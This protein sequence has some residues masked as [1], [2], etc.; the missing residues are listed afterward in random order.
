MLTISI[1][2]F[3]RLLDFI[4]GPILGHFWTHLGLF[5][6]LGHS[7]WTSKWSWK[8]CWGGFVGLLGVFW[9]V[10]RPLVEVLVSV[11]GVLGSLCGALG[12]LCGALGILGATGPAP[13]GAKPPW[14]R[15]DWATP[16]ILRWFLGSL[17]VTLVGA[18]GDSQTCRQTAR[19][20]HTTDRHRQRQTDRK[21]GKKNVSNVLSVSLPEQV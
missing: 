5:G 11:W 3:G 21:T 9:E 13:K 12:S 2:H 18:L 15:A 20:Q 7:K 6:C 14:G 19:Q 4:L 10:K 8:V 17:W 1:L 16:V